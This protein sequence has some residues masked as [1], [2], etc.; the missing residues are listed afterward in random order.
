MEGTMSEIRLFAANFAPRTWAYCYGQQLAINSN[1]ALF[2]L[3]GTT[4]GGNGTTTFALPDFRGRIPAGTG[5]AAGIQQLPMGALL[6]TPNYTLNN[7][8]MPPHT[9][10]AQGTYT[11]KGL[12]DQGNTGAAENAYLASLANL[13]STKPADGF[14][15]TITPTV[16][17][18][19]AGGSQPLPIQQ[20]YLGMNYII[21]IQGIYPSRN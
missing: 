1:Q 14:L 11:L 19:I 20:P 17:V 16:T 9:H 15:K 12:S 6:G 2:S 18:S 3:L 5:V 8:N 10:T 7:S 21:C 13:Y 4:Y